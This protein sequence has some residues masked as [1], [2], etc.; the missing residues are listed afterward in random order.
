VAPGR[1]HFDV[2][3]GLQDPRGAL[4]EALLGGL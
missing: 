2:I 4:T 1:H 3:A